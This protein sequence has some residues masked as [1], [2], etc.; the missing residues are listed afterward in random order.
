M[1]VNGQIHILLHVRKNRYKLSIGVIYF[2][3]TK[4]TGTFELF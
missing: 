1:S 4:I 2:S 3:Y